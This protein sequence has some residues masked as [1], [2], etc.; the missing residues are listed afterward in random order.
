[1][2]TVPATLNDHIPNSTPIKL[3]KQRG[4]NINEIE[5]KEVRIEKRNERVG[6]RMRDKE[7]GLVVRG[8]KL[9]RAKKR[10]TPYK[11][12]LMKTS[13]KVSFVFPFHHESEEFA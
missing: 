3:S 2:K 9:E 11:S 5:R 10:A 1:V 8:R 6:G 13:H 4:C 12:R 7:S